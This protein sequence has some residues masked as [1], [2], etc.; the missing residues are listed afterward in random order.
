[1]EK[2]VFKDVI[3]YEGLYQV[4]NYGNVKSLKRYNIFYCGLRN[5]FLKRPVKEKILNFNKSK[6]G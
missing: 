2:E 5:E 4:S 1:M 3:G 6:R